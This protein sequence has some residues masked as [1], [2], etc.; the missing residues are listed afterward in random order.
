M[1][2]SYLTYEVH[3][4]P[5]W[6]TF[7]AGLAINVVGLLTMIVVGS[8]LPT[9]VERQ[10]LATNH[11]TLIAPVMEPV[12]HHTRPQRIP[13]PERV[14]RL[15]TPKLSRPLHV[16]PPLQTKIEPPKIEPPKPEPSRIAAFAPA[17]SLPKPAAP[18]EKKVQTNVFGAQG[19]Q[20]ATVQ[21]PAR[22][23]QTGGFGDPNGVRGQ[24]D[25]KRNTVTVASVGS[26][27]LPPGEGKGNGTGGSR[28][29]S[30]TVRSAGFSDGTASSGPHGRGNGGGVVAGGFGAVVVAQSTS[31]T[32]QVQKKPDVQGVEIVYKPRP[33][34]T[35]EARRMGIEGEVLLD[36]VFTASGSLRINRVV[37]GL[38]YGLDD[39]ALAAA[40]HIR[41]RPARKDG[42]PYDCAALVHIVFELA[43]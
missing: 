32:Q 33:T 8:H 20:T 18:V 3:R 26:F 43:E 31:G 9:V 22:E 4:P 19:S 7:F 11:I 25:P 23:V 28:G 15:E 41:Y 5:R 17:A 29:V 16:K 12:I 14:A 1:A 13:V 27:D 24:G 40:Q 35:P 34:Y 38:G 6:N 30:G 37:K 39:T 2:L 36:V 21:K 10:P 42:Q